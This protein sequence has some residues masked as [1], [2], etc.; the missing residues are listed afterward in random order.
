[1]P[2]M[3]SSS[4]AK[5]RFK[6]TASGKLKRSRAFKNHILN[7]KS[8]K[9]KMHLRQGAYVAGNQEKTIRNMIPYK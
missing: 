8:S 7:K 5:K 1:M 2:K 6:V 9:R 4:T 3:K